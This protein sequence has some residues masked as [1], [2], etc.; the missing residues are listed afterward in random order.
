MVLRIII[1][2]FLANIAYGLD[3][4]TITPESFL[5]E[6][7]SLERKEIIDYIVHQFDSKR[8]K[9]MN[10]AQID[11]LWNNYSARKTL[12]MTRFQIVNQKL[13][14]ESYNP[15][16]GY[17]LG[18]VEALQRLLKLYKI[19]DTDFIM[20]IREEIPKT[21]QLSSLTLETPGFM[22][23]RDAY[24]PYEINQFLFP[25]ANFLKNDWLS[26]LTRI[27]ESS[28]HNLWQNKINKLF[29]RGATT[30]DEYT[31]ANFNKLIRVK[32]VLL[33][34]LYPDL[35]D[36]KFSGTSGRMLNNPNGQ[37]LEFIL[38]NLSKVD[39]TSVPEENSLKY[40][41]LLSVDG[42]SSTGTRIPWVM[43]SDSVL[44]KQESQKSQWYYTALKPYIHYIPLKEDLTDIFSQITWMKQ[45]DAELLQI[46]HNAH[47]FV[48]NNLMP[49]HIDAH[50]VIILNEYASIS[51]D[52]QIIVSL[53]PAEDLLS[54]TALVGFL[55]NN[56]I[57]KV[58]SWF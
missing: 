52:K 26:L 3:L 8:E 34:A 30:G 1:L 45:H 48:K 39:P 12:R 28:G 5:T 55:K 20:Y 13:Y 15:I 18:L 6:N 42:N 24:S 9:G 37:D 38:K 49:E 47:N 23:F 54:F 17:F 51:K 36:A 25:D 2:I 4:K 16:H 31:L 35:I 14:A 33:S 46:R 58:K 41:Y 57:Q 21:A 53:T 43:Y 44:I 40:K 19:N 50:A 29:W 10:Q 32:A 7:P 27:E 11:K 22:M 56:F